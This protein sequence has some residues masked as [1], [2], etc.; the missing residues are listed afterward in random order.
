MHAART[1]YQ[2]E[3][4][5]ALYRGFLLAQM[6]WGPYNAIYLPLWEASKKVAVKFS[7]AES[8][9]KLAVQYELGSAF[10]S[11]S[12]A[13]ALTNPAVSVYPPPSIPTS[14]SLYIPLLRTIMN[15]DRCLMDSF[16]GYYKD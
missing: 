9:E 4:A 11:A 16:A 5:A 15:D 2:L 3:G 6:V 8:K 13:S 7:E 12:I 10:F 1:I 14:R